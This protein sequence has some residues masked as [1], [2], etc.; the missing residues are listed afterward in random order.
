MK[1]KILQAP[2]VYKTKILTPRV[3]LDAEF[4][5]AKPTFNAPAQTARTTILP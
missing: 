4:P 3:R 5:P 1:E 2:V